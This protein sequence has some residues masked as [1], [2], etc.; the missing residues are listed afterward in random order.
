MSIAWRTV[1]LI[2]VQIAVLLGM[3]GMKQWTLDTGT[4]VVLET[5]PVDP[6][7]LFSGDYVRLG[8]TISNLRLDQLGGDREFKRHDRIYVA[9]QTGTPYAMPVAIYH[10]MPAARAGQV[11]IRGEVEH[12]GSEFWN[13]RTQNIEKDVRNVLVRYGIE[14]YYVPEGTGRALERPAGNAKIAVRV[15]VDRS[16]TAGILGIL[17]NGEERYQQSLLY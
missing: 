3:I 15:A 2:L 11:V 8:Y 13:P 4:P 1:L 14:N 6:R 9:L 10:Q 16:G 17:V 7:S 5:A 12:M